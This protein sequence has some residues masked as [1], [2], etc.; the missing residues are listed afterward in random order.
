MSRVVRGGSFNNNNPE[1]LRSTNRN[2]NAPG[3]RNNNN[4]FRFS[5]TV[6]QTE[7]TLNEVAGIS[8]F[9]GPVSVSGAVHDWLPVSGRP[10]W[11]KQNRDP[12]GL[13]GREVR[14]SC[15]IS[16]FPQAE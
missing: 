8:G 16:V 7:E 5:S 6:L 4:G 13:V 3:N 1:N 10:F 12:V 15:R 2:N 9:T 11:P 14:T